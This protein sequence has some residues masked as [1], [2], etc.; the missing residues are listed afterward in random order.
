MKKFVYL[1]LFSAI[2]SQ[3]AIPENNNTDNEKSPSLIIVKPVDNV[4]DGYQTQ[5]ANGASGNDI[6]IV[7]AIRFNIKPEE[8]K[9]MKQQKEILLSAKNEK[10]VDFDGNIKRIVYKEQFLDVVLRVG[11]ASLLTFQDEFGNNLPIETFII[12][13]SKIKVQ[14]TSSNRLV[15]N[16]VEKYFSTNMI[17]MLKDYD[18]PIHIRIKEDLI[19]NPDTDLTVLVPNNYSIKDKYDPE[20]YSGSIS[21]KRILTQELMKNGE[22]LDS[23]KI[24]FKIVDL[25]NNQLVENIDLFSKLKFIKVKRLNKEFLIS[26]L[27]NEYTLVGES[28][29]NFSRYNNTKNINFLDPSTKILIITNKVVDY[30]EDINFIEKKGKR[31]LSQF[32]KYKIMLNN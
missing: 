1:I 8:I 19:A 28:Y 25:N 3:A 16:P 10:L 24:D 7:D 6:N 32:K 15:I 30:S 27:D 21:L 9:K 12:G 26:E 22:I 23:K 4:T 5:G 14:Q 31:E 18:K 13:E 17:I 29:S 11:Y 20:S 2:I